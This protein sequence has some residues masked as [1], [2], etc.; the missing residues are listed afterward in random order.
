MRTA[1]TRP[2]PVSRRSIPC[3]R[4]LHNKIVV[5]K[6]NKDNKTNL[7]KNI[8]VAVIEPDTADGTQQGHG[9][10]QDHRQR[11]RQTLILCGEDEEHQQH[12][13]RENV[14]GCIPGKDLLIG[15]LGPFE[16]H[17]FGQYFARDLRD[18]ILR[19]VRRNTRQGAAIDIG[20][21]VAVVAHDWHSP[22][23]PG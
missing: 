12:A 14:Y 6:T 11:Q 19:N 20:G 3:T 16:A 8:I 13:K 7:R 2:R 10:N 22:P 23:K 18:S 15:Q 5:G 17:A 21:H 4:K 1:P 9:D